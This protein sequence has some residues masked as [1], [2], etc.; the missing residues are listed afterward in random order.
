MQTLDLNNLSFQHVKLL[1]DIHAEMKEEFN[2]LVEHIY[3]KTDGSLDWL[4]NS[5]LSRNNYLST[6]FLDLCY[7]ELIKTVLE[8]NGI[9]QVI[10]RSAA[11]KKILV[12]YFQQTGKAIRVTS[13][14]SLKQHLKNL[15]TTIYRCL[16]HIY[17][18]AHSLSVKDIERRKRIPRDKEITL[19]DT[20][21]LSSMFKDGVYRDRYYPGLVENLTEEERKKVFFVPSISTR[22]KLKDIIRISE[23]ADEQFIFKFDYL[24]FWDYLHALLSP[25]RIK[26]I[27]MSGFM[28]RGFRIG[29]VL[30]SNFIKS[31][32]NGSSFSAI[33]NYHFFKRLKECGIR[34]GLVIDWFENQP[35]DRGFNKGKRVFFPAVPSIG[36]QGFIV[37]YDFNFYLQP[38]VYE[39]EA[40][41]IPRKI[42]VVGKDL[43]DVVRRYC[44]QLPVVSAPAFRFAE[45]YNYQ[46]GESVKVSEKPSILIVLPISLEDSIDIMEMVAEAAS[47]GADQKAT[48]LIKPHPNLNLSKLKTALQSWPEVFKVID[49]NFSELITE[50][51]LIVGNASSTCMEALAYGV[52]VVVVG[53]Q[54]GVTQNPIPDS[55]PK[56]MWELCYTS[57]ELAA[58]IQRL[59]FE[60]DDEVMSEF[61][62]IGRQIRKEYFEPVTREGI[63]KLL[64]IDYE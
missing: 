38:T 8:K 57:D 34:L 35:I 37:S 21:F 5:L 64:G 39:L 63:M 6:V 55:I 16:Q 44:Q 22:K 60:V 2:E 56:A 42:A 46:L 29:P 51:N 9:E 24:K 7:L 47:N 33:L 59:C 32:A 61:V 12:D 43:I 19:I 41:V 23:K 18:I 40:G 48:F 58:A 50:S 10:V 30:K 28:F 25:L 17:S 36:Y 54:N 13:T 20:F 31:I 45:I 27:D 15:L 53:S 1:N 52:P 49:G 26:R 62:R 11:H 14:V 3:Q 4:V